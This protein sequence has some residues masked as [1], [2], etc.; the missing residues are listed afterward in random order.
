[1]RMASSG[2][3]P[4]EFGGVGGGGAGRCRRIEIP[5]ART[6]RPARI[7]PR[8]MRNRPG[9]VCPV[10]WD[11][12][13]LV[14]FFFRVFRLRI[15]L[16]NRL[17]KLDGCEATAWTANIVV[18]PTKNVRDPA[19]GHG[20]MPW[21]PSRSR[22]ANHGILP[23]PL[24]SSD[25]CVPTDRLGS[26]PFDGIFFGAVPPYTRFRWLANQTSSVTLTE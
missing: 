23:T 2:S 25:S 24:Y 21:Q 6:S 14:M 11:A 18:W 17:S 19:R 4:S 26:R 5:T 16:D 8:V 9:A 1:M 20:V 12:R 22:R 3:S 7:G 10:P 15:A 13:P